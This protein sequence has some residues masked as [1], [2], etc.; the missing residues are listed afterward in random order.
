M[1]DARFEAGRAKPFSDRFRQRDILLGTFAKTPTTHAI[2]ILGNIGYDF[3]VIDE[4]HA[5]IDRESTDLMLLASRAA[6]IAGI[7][8]VS[9]HA[10]NDILRALDAGAAGILVPHV[11]SVARATEVVSASRYKGGMRGFSNSPRAADYGRTGIWDHVEEQDRNVLVIAMIEDKEALDDIGG[12]VSVPGIDGVFI[13]RGDL[14]VSLGAESAASP[15][16]KRAVEQ[17]V[18]A[19]RQAGKPVCLMV[20][21]VDEAKAFGQQGVSA[22]IIASDQGFMRIGA[23]KVRKEFTEGMNQMVEAKQ[24]VRS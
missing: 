14:T 19:C 11:N 22:F 16:V 12:I 24:N 4:E 17:V 23:M 5:P 9:T 10:A 6:G 8:R 20:G 1:T 3:A 15:A 2:E 21:S 7:V 18:E 13:G